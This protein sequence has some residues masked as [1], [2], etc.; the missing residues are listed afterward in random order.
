MMKCDMI[1]IVDL[2]G[3]GEAIKNG[4]YARFDLSEPI[5]DSQQ[6]KRSCNSAATKKMN[7]LKNP[8]SNAYI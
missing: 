7:L 6:S 1:V 4:G 8:D 5:N 3:D 2:N